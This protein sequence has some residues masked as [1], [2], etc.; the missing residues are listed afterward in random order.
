MEKLTWEEVDKAG[1]VLLIRYVD[2]ADKSCAQSIWSLL[3]EDGLTFYKDEISKTKSWILALGLLEFVNDCTSLIRDDSYEQ[4]VSD[5]AYEVGINPFRIAQILG[6]DF[7][8]DDDYDEEELNELGLIE[9][10][11]DTR[12]TIV[13]CIIKKYNGNYKVYR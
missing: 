12:A 10:V 2:G 13:S 6:P 9:L 5:W 7:E 3:E 8:I 11:S 4:S 1:S